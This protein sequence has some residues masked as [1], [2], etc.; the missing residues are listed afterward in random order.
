MTKLRPGEERPRM[1]CQVKRL[2]KTLA[3]G[4]TADRE[5]VLIPLN[6]T[7]TKNLALGDIV[8]FVPRE[9][10]PGNFPE[11]AKFYAFNPRIMAHAIHPWEF[12]ALE[13]E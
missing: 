7:Q 5:R 12:R 6:L 8:S 4:Y 1:W 3:F 13:E 2:C 9:P 10:L 11:P